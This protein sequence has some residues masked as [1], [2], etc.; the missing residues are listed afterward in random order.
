MYQFKIIFILVMLCGQSAFATTVEEAG[1]PL[2]DN[3]PIPSNNEASIPMLEAHQSSKGIATSPY[4]A[5]HATTGVDFDGRNSTFVGNYFGG[6]D[7]M[8]DAS[9]PEQYVDH[10]IKLLDGDILRWIDVWGNDSNVD[11]DLSIFIYRSCLPYLS[12]GSIDYSFE[13]SADIARSSGDFIH[14]AF[15]NKSFKGTE[16][17]C[18]LMARIRF[19]DFGSSCATASDIRLYKVRAE[20]RRDDLI[21]FDNFQLY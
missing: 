3:T 2:G 18:K 20:I 8:C 17:Y 13:Y 10:E 11:E 21:Y 6:G 7:R 16:S 14:S 15:L 1:G 12:A 19:A 5:Y 9:S 4:T